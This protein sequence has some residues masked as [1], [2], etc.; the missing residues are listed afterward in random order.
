VVIETNL[1]DRMNNV[2]I[3]AGVI[4]RFDQPMD[5]ASVERALSTVPDTTGAFTWSA[6][7]DEVRYQPGAFL[8]VGATYAVYVDATAR[9]AAGVEMA[10]TYR[11]LFTTSTYD[12]SC[13]PRPWR[14]PRAPCIVVHQTPEDGAL[15][16][17]PPT[18]TWKHNCTWTRVEYASNAGLT[19]NRR[20]GRWRYSV[21]AHSVRARDWTAYNADATIDT[22]YWRVRGRSRTGVSS[23]SDTK[24]I[25]VATEVEAN[26]ERFWV[27]KTAADITSSPITGDVPITAPYDVFTVVAKPDDPAGFAAGP[28]ERVVCPQPCPIPDDLL[29]HKAAGAFAAVSAMFDLTGIDVPP[30]QRP[31]DIHLTS[32]VECGDY[33]TLAAEDPGGYVY[34]FSGSRWPLAGSYMCLWEWDDPNRILLFRPEWAAAAGQDAVDNASRMEAQGVLVHEYGH[35][36]F[37]P[38]AFASP[39]DWVKTFD[40]VT[41]GIWTG[42]G[43]GPDS[44]PRVTTACDPRLDSPGGGQMIYRL[45]T[46]CGFELED[47]SRVM[48]RIDAIWAAGLG[49]VWLGDRWVL[50]N[51]QFKAIIDDIVGRDSATACGVDW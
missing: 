2:S 45:C 35:I 9:S 17:L 32:S 18:L 1:P 50:S 11:T 48:N 3:A 21:G 34:R 16:G 43:Y 10:G 27:Q 36:L 49:E 26:S 44:F 24:R 46:N 28:T 4:L 47:I 13:G 41:T 8:E 29:F 6:G 14:A 38:R 30:A 20:R 31:V 40:F 12:F 33:A 15:Q 5:T 7:L 39:E 25:G 42:S 22:L 51:A 23:W 19:A 37:Y